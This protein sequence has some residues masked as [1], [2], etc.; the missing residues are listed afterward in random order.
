MKRAVGIV[1]ALLLCLALGAG[2]LLAASASP[3]PAPKVKHITSP[4]AVLMVGNSFTYFNNGVMSHLLPMLRETDPDN[5]KAYFFKQVTISGASLSE[6]RF[7]FE[8]MVKSRKWDVVVLQGNSTEPMVPATEEERQALRRVQGAAAPADP[9]AAAAEFKEY[10]RRYDK[11]IRDN[12][13]VPVFFMTWAYT[14]QPGMTKPLAE[15]YTDIANELDDLV[16]PVGLAFERSLRTRPDYPMLISDD[17]HPTRAGTYLIACTFYAALTGKSP[18]G[19]KTDAGL[20]PDA[21]YLQTVAQD[22]VTEFYGR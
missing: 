8:E 21:R 3:A 6:H 15:A 22:T 1:T 10:A 9:M 7:G 20:G 16:V 14:G 5:A 11:I 19:L 12:G 18:V 13:G 17:R 4:K 2:V